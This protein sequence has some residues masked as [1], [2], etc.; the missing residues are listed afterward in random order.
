MFRA[1]STLKLTLRDRLAN[2]AAQLPRVL[3]GLRVHAG[4]AWGRDLFARRES[5]TAWAEAWVASDEAV[6]ARR[7]YPRR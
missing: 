4:D 1:I 3:A 5:P 6:R 7:I 2:I